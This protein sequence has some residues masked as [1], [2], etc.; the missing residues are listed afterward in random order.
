MCHDQVILL[1]LISISF[2]EPW[3]RKHIRFRVLGQS[4]GTHMV[5]QETSD[6]QPEINVSQLAS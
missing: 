6:R 5:K 4:H 3:I 2:R 1:I